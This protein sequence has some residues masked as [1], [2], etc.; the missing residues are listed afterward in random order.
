M[1]NTAVIILVPGTRTRYVRYLVSPGTSRYKVGMWLTW[2]AEDAI[3]W[4]GEP[5]AFLFIG[6]YVWVG[7]SLLLYCCCWAICLRVGAVMRGWFSNPE[8]SSRL[9]S[10]WHTNAHT[11]VHT[12]EV[13]FWLSQRGDLEVRLLWLPACI[14]SLEHDLMEYTGTQQPQTVQREKMVKNEGGGR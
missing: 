13:P 12:Q 7:A 11:C 9:C 5:Q 3:S 1:R 10:V 6:A 8:E 14:H 4:K 2:N